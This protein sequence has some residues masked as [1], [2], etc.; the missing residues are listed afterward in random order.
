MPQT[1]FNE[2][3]DF[4]PTD[5]PQSALAN[6]MALVRPTG[7]CEARTEECCACARTL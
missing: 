2:D 4:G 6:A 3:R 5:M 1:V 7:A